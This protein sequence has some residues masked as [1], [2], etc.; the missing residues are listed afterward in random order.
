[1]CRMSEE[2]ADLKRPRLLMAAARAGLPAYRRR[3]D[4]RRMLRAAIP[5][6]P[7]RALEVLLPIER[8]L[9]HRR[10][11][12]ENYSLTR[13]VDILIALLGEARAFRGA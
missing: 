4:L 11:T 9:E 5:A 10:R 3:R 12:G 7:N 2:L 1:M 8:A 6:T 13:H